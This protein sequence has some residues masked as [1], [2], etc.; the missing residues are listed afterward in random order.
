MGMVWRSGT[1]FDGYMESVQD[2]LGGNA[3]SKEDEKVYAEARILDQ[4]LDEN[5]NLKFLRALPSSW[6]QVALTLKTKG[7]LELLSFDDLYYKLKTLEAKGKECQAKIF[8][9]QEIQRLERINKNSK[10]SGGI[11][12]DT[13]VDW[14][15]HDCQSDGVITP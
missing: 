2:R 1:T 9:I 8:L 7:G 12:V 15:E 4:T 5:I 3:E 10:A 14:T 11:T 6:S 13:L